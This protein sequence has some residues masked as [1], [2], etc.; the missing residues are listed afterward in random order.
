M[1]SQAK[2]ALAESAVATCPAAR[3]GLKKTKAA[4]IRCTTG[5]GGGVG[6]EDFFGGG[7]KFLE[8]KQGG[9]W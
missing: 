6:K 1:F 9:G 8:W 2:K 5:V 3:N 7:L 4:F